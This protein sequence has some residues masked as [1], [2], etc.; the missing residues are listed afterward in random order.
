VA[1]EAAR[2]RLRLGAGVALR[3]RSSRRSACASLFT[4]ANRRPKQIANP[5]KITDMDSQ[6]CPEASFTGKV[7]RVRTKNEKLSNN[8]YKTNLA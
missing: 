7:S 6:A 8:F 2:F 4:I 3:L 5:A 1:A